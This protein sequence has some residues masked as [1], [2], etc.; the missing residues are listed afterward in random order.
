MSTAGVQQY[1]DHGG[2]LIGRRRPMQGHSPRASR[3]D[4]RASIQQRG[5]HGGIRAERRRPMQGRLA[6]L[7]P[8]LDV[9]L[10]CLGNMGE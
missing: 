2:I 7:G 1:N 4:I 3:L 9:P 6:L 8:R 10:F 5:N